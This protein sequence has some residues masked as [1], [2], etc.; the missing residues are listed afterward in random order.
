MDCSMFDAWR[1]VLLTDISALNTSLRALCPDISELCAWNPHRPRITPRSTL[2]AWCRAWMPPCLT[3]SAPYRP[4]IAPYPVLSVPRRAW[5]AP[6]STLSALRCSPIA[7]CSALETPHRLRIAPSTTLNARPRVR[8]A[9]RSMP[10]GSALYTDY[11]AL[12]AFAH[13]VSRGL[14]RIP[15]YAPV[16]IADRSALDT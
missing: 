13:S 15:P 11:S 5:I 14:L 12:H 7:R 4:R 10:S 3:P 2:D 9:P 6:C 8:I 1:P 16:P